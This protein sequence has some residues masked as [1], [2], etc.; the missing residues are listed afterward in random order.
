MTSETIYQPYFY[1]I[2]HKVT[3]KMY[4]GSRWAKGC[5]PNEFMQLDGYTT[6]SNIIN[7]IIDQEGLDSFDVLRIDTNLDRVSAYDYETLFL[8]TIDASNLDM[9]FNKQNNNGILINS[10]EFKNIMVEKF[11]YEYALQSKI[12]LEK[13]KNTCMINYGV[14]HNSQ[15]PEIKAKQVAT[16]IITNL[17][18]YGVESVSQVPEFKSRQENTWLENYGV[19]NPSQLKFMSIIETKKT[20]SKSRITRWFPEFKQYY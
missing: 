6:S 15:I 8:Q 17:E 13:S 12:L 18:K 10:K 11:G 5:H 2:Q 4:A 14:K 19:K 20:Y 16:M 3:K 1:I 7:R 9:W